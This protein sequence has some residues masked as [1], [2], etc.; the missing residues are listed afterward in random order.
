CCSTAAGVPVHGLSG[1]NGGRDGGGSAC[2]NSLAGAGS[3][4]LDRIGAE[5]PFGGI[6]V[7]VGTRSVAVVVVQF[8]CTG[9]RAGVETELAERLPDVRIGGFVEAGGGVAGSA[10]DDD[11]DVAVAAGLVTTGDVNLIESS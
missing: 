10:A 5:D 3:G 7:H 6:D 2:A 1:R 11:L 8:D 4:R 9:V